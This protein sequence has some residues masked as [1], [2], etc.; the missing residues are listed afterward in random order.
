MAKKRRKAEEIIKIVREADQGVSV[1]KSSFS[2]KVNAAI[3]VLHPVKLEALTC[4]YNSADGQTVSLSFSLRWISFSYTGS[5]DNPVAAVAGEARTKF[6][7][8]KYWE[9]GEIS[10]TSNDMNVPYPYE[11]W[12][13]EFEEKRVEE[14]VDNI[15][16]FAVDS[17]EVSVQTGVAIA[18]KTTHTRNVRIKQSKM[19]GE[20]VSGVPP[21]RRITPAYSFDITRRHGCSCTWAA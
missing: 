17:T 14:H 20:L 11:F 16:E 18:A 6:E 12:E 3:K 1:P 19:S 5:E 13:K 2:G 21:E 10:F 8:G 4:E 9:F 7:N 15:R